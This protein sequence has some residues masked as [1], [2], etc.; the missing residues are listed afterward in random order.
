[1]TGALLPCPA[2]GT[3]TLTI[4]LTILSGTYSANDYL[5]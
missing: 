3:T 5:R 1:M 4:T 2:R